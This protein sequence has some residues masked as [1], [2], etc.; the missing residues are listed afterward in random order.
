MFLIENEKE[1]KE[2]FSREETEESRKSAEKSDE[3]LRL[4]PCRA[5]WL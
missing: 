2:K 3:K 5:G 4:R 1:A